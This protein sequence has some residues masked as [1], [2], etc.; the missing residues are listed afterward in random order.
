MTLLTVEDLTIEFPR[1]GG[2]SG[3][4][5]RPVRG[6]TLTVEPGQTLG[7]V[8]E[9]GCG[10]TLTGLAVLGLLPP[11]AQARGS[12]RL[13]GREL[14]GAPPSQ[15]RAVRGSAIA[16]VF[17]N[18][19]T[20]F[21]PVR[22][23]RI[24]FERVIRRHRG[25]SREQARARAVKLLAE[26]ELH[27]TDR[28]LGSY[29][30][31]LSGGMLQRAMIAL[32]L[33]CD[34]RLIIA[35]EATS[36]LDVTVAQQVRRLLLRLQ[37]A[38]GFG[39]L[40]VTHNLGEARDL[41]DRVAVLYAGEVVETGPVEDVFTAPAHPYTKALLAAVPT[42]DDDGAP[43]ASLPGEVPADVLAVTGCVFANRCPQVEDLCR[44]TPPAARTLHGG[45]S[46]LC[47]FADPEVAA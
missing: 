30:H 44:S 21:D 2:R 19:A 29:P 1:P 7:V 13:D 25:G 9:T 10:K 31:Q 15:L 27:D 4:T 22:P 17:Q 26:V 39:V 42:V 33:S 12:I 20:A 16:M 3:G 23:L 14:L 47:H 11:A 40:F 8:G 46:A 28:V 41:C 38:H 43:L 37:H 35:D 36:A 45:R 18:P 5:T 34:P 32:A 24:Q 6:V